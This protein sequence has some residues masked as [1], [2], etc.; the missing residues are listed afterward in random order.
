MVYFWHTVTE[1]GKNETE[2]KRRIEI[3][4]SAFDKK[5]KILTSRSITEET[6]ELL[7]KCYICSTLLYGTETWTLTKAVWLEKLKPLKCEYIGDF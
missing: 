3:A 1:D 2:I 5:S 4:G 7:D 6:N